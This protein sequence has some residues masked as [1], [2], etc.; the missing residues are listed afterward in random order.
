VSDADDVDRMQRVRDG[1]AQAFRDLVERWLRPLASFF[2]RLGADPSTAEDCSMEVFEKLYRT[3]SAYEVRARF[4]TYLFS[5]ARHHWIDL[6]RHRS[7]LPTTISSDA[8]DDARSGRAASDS[9]VAPGSS[10]SAGV[11]ERE[12]LAAIR[13]AVDELSPE[14]QEVFALAQSGLRYQDIAEVL[15]IPLGT[16][17]SRMHTAVA[18]LKERLERAGFEP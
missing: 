5:I 4:S 14:H 16:V 13:R 1:D 7:I 8:T 2:H 18:F 15:S 3:R 12:V 6:V 10:P 17:K 11:E 9:F